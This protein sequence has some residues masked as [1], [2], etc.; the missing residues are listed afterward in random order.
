MKKE[1]W[2]RN[3]AS[4]FIIVIHYSFVVSIAIQFLDFQ[5][6][7]QQRWYIDVVGGNDDSKFGEKFI[8]TKL[9]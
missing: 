5:T 3:T 8:K 7:D 2:F 9:I 6:N 1:N 4:I